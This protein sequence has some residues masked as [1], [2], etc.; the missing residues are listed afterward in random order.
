MAVEMFLEGGIRACEIGSV[1]FGKRPD[2]TE[3]PA[4][5]ELV[6]LAVPRRVYTKEHIDYAVSIIKRVRK[7]AASIKGLRIRKQPDFLRHFTAEF[8]YQ[9]DDEPMT[10]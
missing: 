4:S 3:Q 1:M 10:K 8:E 6:R 7:R 2:G 5:M 9:N